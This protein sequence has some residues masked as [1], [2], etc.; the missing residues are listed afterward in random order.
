MTMKTINLSEVAMI[1]VVIML[2]SIAL[3]T[4]IVLI[5]SKMGEKKPASDQIFKNWYMVI[6]EMIKTWPN[7]KFVNDLIEKQIN[8]LDNYKDKDQEYIDVLNSELE[9]RIERLES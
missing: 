7:N 2:C 1:I 6:D 9:R 5:V 8:K 4:A 3:S